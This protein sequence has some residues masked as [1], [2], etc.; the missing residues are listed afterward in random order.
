MLGKTGGC[1]GIR[2]NGILLKCFESPALLQE[3]G[4]SFADLEA[5]KLNGKTD[6]TKI[7]VRYLAKTNL[8][9]LFELI[10]RLIVSQIAFSNP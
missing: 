10:C 9:W 5:R 1:S 6:A 4:A 3:E 7:L 8:L 2:S